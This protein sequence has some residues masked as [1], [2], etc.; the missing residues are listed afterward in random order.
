V[1]ALEIFNVGMVVS[2]ALLSSLDLAENLLSKASAN[3]LLS[4]LASVMVVSCARCWL[5][6]E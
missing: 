1:L 4:E 6:L 5:A 3:L 2:R